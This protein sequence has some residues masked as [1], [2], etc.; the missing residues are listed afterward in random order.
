M[1][2]VSM[3][4]GYRVALL[5]A[6]AS[7]LAPMAD[8]RPVTLEPLSSF[9]TPDTGYPAFATDVAIDGDYALATAARTVEDPGGDPTLRQDFATAFLFRR[10][11]TRWEPVRRLLETRQVRTFPIPLAVA[12]Q[13][14]LAAVQ[15]ARTDIWKLT[16]TGWVRQPAALSVDGPGNHLVVDG[17]RVLSGDG[18]APWNGLVFQPDSSGTWRT[19]A[20]LQGKTRAAGGD[21]EFRGGSADLSGRW[22]VVMQPDGE[23]DPVPEAFIYFDDGGSQGWNP[24]PY[25]GARPPEGATRFGNEVA[26]RWPDVFV[27][28]GNESGTYLFREV[29][30]FGFELATRIQALDSFMGSGPAGSFAHTDQLLLQHAWSHDRHASVVNVFQRRSDGTFGHV[31]VLAARNGASLGRAI[32]ISGRRVL[33]GDNGNGLVHYFELPAT[34]ATPARIQDTFATGNGTGWS[35]SA[36]SS[37][38]TAPRGISRVLRQT[39]VAIATRAVLDAFDFAS[40]AIEADVRAIRFGASTASVGLATR[41]Q[42]ADNFFAAVLRNDGRAELHRRAGG[43]QRL[44][45]SAAFRVV[46]GR[47]YRVRFESAGTLHRLLVDGRLIVDADSGGPTHGRA[48][49][50]TDRAQAEF[51]NVIVSPALATT[52]Y[53]NDFETAPGPWTRTSL[54]F[55]NL[56]VGG[57]TVYSQS[58]VAGDA[59]A[60]IGGPADD[61]VVRVRARLDTFATP[62]GT[63]ER[64]FGVMAR[65]VDDRNF[66]YLSLRSS[67][68]VSLRKVVDGTVTTLA[69]TPF[70]VLPASWYQL[71]LDAIGNTLRAYVNGSL[72]LEATDGA[73][74]RGNSGPA[75]FKA[76]VDFDDFSAYQP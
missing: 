13:N 35:V 10:N 3:P 66:Y 22:A 29:P 27:A 64:W 16:A 43:T 47:N 72:L 52:I 26:I 33:V 7:L 11:G 23:D 14:G 30:A 18:T 19:A 74:P 59:R 25:G 54:G 24:F 46:A 36:G 69:S 50:L 37:F 45:A 32:A 55:W 58:S 34:F 4:A 1:P 65:H 75:M 31:A 21:D 39:Q 9:G 67:N 48:A 71:R 76:A 8:A 44:L 63:Q 53:A 51:D 15:T 49:L 70:A 38:G 12:M 5:S 40:E 28:G 17:G 61:Q 73:L 57:T 68:T 62:N 60:S 20:V 56:T 2:K 42:D 41:F 6:A